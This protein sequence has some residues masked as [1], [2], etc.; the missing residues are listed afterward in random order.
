MTLPY[1]TSAHHKNKNKY[2]R[3]QHV[4]FSVSVGIERQKTGGIRAVHEE[5]VD[6]AGGGGGGPP[7]DLQGVRGGGG[8][9]ASGPT[10]HGAPAQGEGR[11]HPPGRKEESLKYRRNFFSILTLFSLPSFG[12]FRMKK[13]LEEQSLSAFKYGRTGPFS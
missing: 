8:V 10:V 5:E 2:K 4:L 3:N 13:R 9:L 12:S 6:R 1:L 7:G 11:K